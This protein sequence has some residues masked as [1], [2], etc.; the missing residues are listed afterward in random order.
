MNK[1]KNKGIILCWGWQK[2]RFSEKKGHSPLTQYLLFS[3]L[4]FLPILQTMHPE[5]SSPY[6]LSVS[7]FTSEM[8]SFPKVPT[9]TSMQ[10]FKHLRSQICYIY[11]YPPL[12]Q[13]PRLEFFLFFPYVSTF[14][15]EYFNESNKDKFTV[16]L[17]TTLLPQDSLMTEYLKS[18][19]IDWAA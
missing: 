10:I 18:L 15:K 12:L 4:S 11:Q 13:P 14:W 9:V 8:D 2:R 5:S 6:L 7:A 1:P 17:K 19:F 16:L 3:I